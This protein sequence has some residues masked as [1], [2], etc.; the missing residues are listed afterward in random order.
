MRFDPIRESFGNPDFMSA[1][2][3]LKNSTPPDAVVIC[4]KPRLS[5]LITGR[6]SSVYDLQASDEQQLK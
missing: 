5:A 3:F 4:R 6:R 2:A 1:C